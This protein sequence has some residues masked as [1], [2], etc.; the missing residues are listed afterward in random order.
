MMRATLTRTLFAMAMAAGL[1]T[2]GVAAAFLMNSP[3]DGG[4]TADEQADRPAASGPGNT[5]GARRRPGPDRRRDRQEDRP[6]KSR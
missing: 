4:F 2:T 5:K 6:D 3:P 1:L